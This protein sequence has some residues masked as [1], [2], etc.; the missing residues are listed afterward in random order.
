MV[1]DSSEPRSLDDVVAAIIETHEKIAH[2]W[3]NLRG[4]PPANAATLLDASRL[5]WLASLAYALRIWVNTKPTPKEHDGRLILA[6]A[7]LGSLFEGAMKFLLCVFANDYGKSVERGRG[8]SVFKNLWDKQKSQAKEPDGLM[9]EVLRQFFDA[10]VWV[11]EQ[12]A[13]WTPWLERIQARRNT[14]HAY[15]NRELGSFDEFK[16]DV[17][18]Y[19][20]FLDDLTGRLPDLPDPPDY[21]G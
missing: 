6:W 8:A 17:R 18:E 16:A 4:W 2:D 1:E 10:E 11:E 15:K 3:K 19:E 5:D 7:N 12:R 9:L 13:R 20:L 21:S 14:I